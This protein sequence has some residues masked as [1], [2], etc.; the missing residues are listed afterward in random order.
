MWSI[1]PPEPLTLTAISSERGG[2]LISGEVRL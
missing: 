1:Q 2:I